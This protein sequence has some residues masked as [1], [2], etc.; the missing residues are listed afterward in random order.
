MAIKYED[1]KDGDILF[2]PEIRWNRFNELL[3]GY[4]RVELGK[5]SRQRKFTPIILYPCTHKGR[6]WGNVA[7]GRA[8][9]SSN[10][11]RV[12]INSP[13][14]NFYSFVELVSKPP[15]HLLLT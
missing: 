6:D 14:S 13:L 1:L 8:M 11:I 7:Y 2:L 3:R 4:S 9:D 10:T 15:A 12:T 5:Y